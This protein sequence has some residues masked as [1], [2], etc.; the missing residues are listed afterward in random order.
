MILLLAKSRTQDVC[1]K[2]IS[3]IRAI[4]EPWVDYLDKHKEQCM[5]H[6]FLAR[7]VRRFGKV[8][9]DGVEN[10]NSSLSNAHSFP[11][12]YM[13]GAIVR[14]QQEKHKERSALVKEWLDNGKTLTGFAQAQDVNASVSVTASLT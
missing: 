11:I 4:H 6:C 8:M 5:T 7:G 10:V 12:V 3:G 2:H 9:S 14:H 1:D 13:V